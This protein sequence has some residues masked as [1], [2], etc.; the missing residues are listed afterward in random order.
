MWPLVVSVS[1]HNAVDWTAV[2][3][4]CHTQLLLGYILKYRTCDVKQTTVVSTMRH[5]FDSVLPD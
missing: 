3:D 2:C 5:D 4:S 1:S